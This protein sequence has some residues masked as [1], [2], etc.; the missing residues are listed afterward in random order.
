LNETAALTGNGTGTVQWFLLPAPHVLLHSLSF[1]L[2]S[3]VLSFLGGT[4]PLQ[5][6]NYAGGGARNFTWTVR[7]PEGPLPGTVTLSASGAFSVAPDYQTTFTSPALHPNTLALTF[8]TPAT[9]FSLQ[10]RVGT[11]GL[12]NPAVSLPAA[13]DAHRFIAQN[14]IRYLMIQNNTANR[15]AAYFFAAEYGFVP[16]FQNSQ[17][18]VYAS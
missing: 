11:P 8:D 6:L 7:G 13:F 4:V 10:L 12:S 16:A 9:G 14:D 1:Q 17:W 18:W 2:A 3:P 15:P 5:R